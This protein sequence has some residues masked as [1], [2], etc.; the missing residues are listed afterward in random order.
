MVSILTVGLL[1]RLLCPD[2]PDPSNLTER[3]AALQI[4]NVSELL[5]LQLLLQSTPHRKVNWI[6][7]LVLAIR[8]PVFWI[9]K[10]R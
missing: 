1:L 9:D 3:T 7:V 4:I 2:L 8:W 5:T 10:F 6:E